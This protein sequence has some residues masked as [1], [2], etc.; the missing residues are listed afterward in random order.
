VNYFPYQ[1]KKA[2][3]VGKK[4]KHAVRRPMNSG[5]GYQHRFDW[6]PSRN[7]DGLEVI[8]DS[9]NTKPAPPL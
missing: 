3:K 5:R 1:E 7:L 8:A 6:V 4:K 9:V 2:G